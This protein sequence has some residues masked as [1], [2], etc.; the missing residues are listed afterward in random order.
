VR[1]E[2]N[3][4]RGETCEERNRLAG[5]Y[6]SLLAESCRSYLRRHSPL[7]RE[8]FRIRFQIMQIIYRARESRKWENCRETS[9]KWSFCGKRRQGCKPQYYY[10]I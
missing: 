2:W 8:R 1:N 10:R 6:V 7:Q 5:P 9:N 3:L 4:E